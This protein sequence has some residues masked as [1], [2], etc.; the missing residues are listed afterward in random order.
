MRIPQSV[1][2]SRRKRLSSALQQALALPESEWPPRIRLPRNRPTGEQE[3][4]FEQRDDRFN[5][6]QGQVDQRQD[7]RGMMRGQLASMDRFLDSHPEVA[8][9]LQISITTVERDFRKACAFLR[10][11]LV[12]DA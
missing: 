8:E 7:G 2:G 4:R 9:Q 10:R 3:Q 5:Q 11:R 12:K 1:Q 6:G